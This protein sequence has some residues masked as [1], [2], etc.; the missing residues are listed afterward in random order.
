MFPHDDEEFMEITGFPQ[1]LVSTY[2]RVYSVRRKMFMT[3]QKI[4]GGAPRV[5]VTIDGKMTSLP[6]APTVLTAFGRR[7]PHRRAKPSFLDGDNANCA[8][9]NLEW[10]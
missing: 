2:G 7:P 4:D 3:F 6:V 5:A 8:L 1:Y 10:V 9:T